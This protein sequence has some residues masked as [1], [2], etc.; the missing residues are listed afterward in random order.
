LFTYTSEEGERTNIDI[1]KMPS[2]VVLKG[3]LRVS[4]F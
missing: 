4:R 1:S 3:G 2:R